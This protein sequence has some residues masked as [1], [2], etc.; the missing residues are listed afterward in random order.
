MKPYPFQ[1]HTFGQI[2]PYVDSEQ[3]AA[4]FQDLRAAGLI[5][6]QGFGQLPASMSNRTQW[7]IARLP[8]FAASVGSADLISSCS[9]APLHYTIGSQRRSCCSSRSCCL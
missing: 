2:L 9:G 1:P 8:S 3:S 4:L 7:Y 6:R 5:D